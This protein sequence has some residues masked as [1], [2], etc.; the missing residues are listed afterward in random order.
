[1]PNGLGTGHLR[2]GT[3]T[4]KEISDKGTDSGGCPHDG[5]KFSRVPSDLDAT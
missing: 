3:L 2:T 4:K 1:M 5:L